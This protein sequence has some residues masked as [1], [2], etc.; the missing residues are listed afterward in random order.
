[1]GCDGVPSGRVAD[2]RGDGDVYGRG[3]DR[4]RLPRGAASTALPA[5]QPRHTSRHQIRQHLT[6]TR[7]AG[8]TQ[9]VL[10]LYLDI[11]ILQNPIPLI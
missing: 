9:Y 1:M 8:Q 7:R 10:L 2:G 6:G 5:R 3:P 11:D 4:R